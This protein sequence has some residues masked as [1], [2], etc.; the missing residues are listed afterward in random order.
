MGATL[1]GGR[2]LT[3]P[4]LQPLLSLGGFLATDPLLLAE[5]EEFYG[6]DLVSG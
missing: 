6:P 1:V 3:S 4:P 5:L 2:S